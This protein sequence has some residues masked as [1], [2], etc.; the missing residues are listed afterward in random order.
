[1]ALWRI[2]PTVQ[3]CDMIN[4]LAKKLISLLEKL[5]SL[6]KLTAKGGEYSSCHLSNGINEGK[7]QK[8]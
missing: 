6:L 3:A 2:Q 8:T 7:R 4:Q 5:V 1:M